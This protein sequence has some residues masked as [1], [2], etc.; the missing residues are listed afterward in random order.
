MNHESPLKTGIITF[1]FT[2]L[3]SLFLISENSYS[4]EEDEVDFGVEEIGNEKVK[5]NQNS[6]FS[7][8]INGNL[9][10]KTTRQIGT[11]KRWM[12]LGPSLKLKGSLK[13][14]LCTSSNLMEIAN[15]TGVLN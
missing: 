14:S 4:F 3:L 12:E 7:I 15:L 9:L 8:D 1:L 5:N 6:S 13:S 10:F 2:L 11:Q